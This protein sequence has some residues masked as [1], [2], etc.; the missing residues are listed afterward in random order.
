MN[1]S[2]VFLCI[3]LAIP[4]G[5]GAVADDHTP[6]DLLSGRNFYHASV[7]DEQKIVPARKVFIRLSTEQPPLKWRAQVYLGALTAIQGKHAFWPQQKLRLVKKGLEQMDRGLRKNPDDLES[8]FVHATLN[9][10]LPFFFTR[11]NLAKQDFE[12][13]IH[14]L[15]A[16]Y[17]N[18]DRE[19]LLDMI[20]YIKTHLE[21]TEDERRVLN[22]VYEKILT[23][24]KKENES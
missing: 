6:A 7:E 13:I 2:Y 16:A 8:L 10:N 5:L 12:R 22:Q 23:Q 3:V 1:R 20:V 9:R 17:P 11:G 18:F 21:L 4:L 14:L 24:K 19:F 15:P